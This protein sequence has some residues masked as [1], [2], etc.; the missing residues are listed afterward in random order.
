M[1]N[2]GTIRIINMEVGM[3]LPNVNIASAFIESYLN[4]R[5][6]TTWKLEIKDNETIK[7]IDPTVD[8][9]ITLCLEMLN[10]FKTAKT[11]ED[12]LKV[13][14]ETYE[15]ERAEF[16]AH[17]NRYAF[18]RAVTYQPLAGQLL[19]AIRTYLI[20]ELKKDPAFQ[21]FKITLTEQNKSAKLDKVI[22]TLEARNDEDTFYLK[23]FTDTIMYYD[24]ESKK[25]NEK[26]IEDFER[27]VIEG[28]R[29]FTLCERFIAEN[30][31]K[32]AV[33]ENTPAPEHK[34]QPLVA[35]DPFKQDEEPAISI[36]AFLAPSSPPAQKF[37]PPASV[38]KN[39]Q[40]PKS[41]PLQNNN[42]HA[43]HR[44]TTRSKKLVTIPPL[45]NTPDMMPLIAKRPR[46]SSD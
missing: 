20:S 33:A 44:Y 41:S 12:W 40:P 38:T 28:K 23:F 11:F 1:F 32:T 3:S 21:E 39:C 7:I 35:N 37:F 24:S 34:E 45:S 42:M 19:R 31:K 15:K 25:L 46:G 9:K 29:T 36:S 22:R 13:L 17:Q 6:K 2:D 5:Q 18:V 30:S 26:T 14:D 16:D 10:K 27:N 4:I 43:Q 8:H